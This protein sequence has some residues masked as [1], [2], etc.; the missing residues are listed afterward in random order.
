M[1][2]IIPSTKYVYN[3]PGLC[4]SLLLGIIAVS[5]PLTLLL[6]FLQLVQ[7]LIR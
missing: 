4:C 3:I 7:L 6:G 5:L 2:V 1:E